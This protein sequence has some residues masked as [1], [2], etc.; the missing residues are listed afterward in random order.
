MREVIRRENVPGTVY[1]IHFKKKFHQ[2]RHYLGWTEGSD[3]KPRIDKH[4]AGAGSRLLRAVGAAGISFKV[5]RTWE[6]VDR[7]FE[8]KLKKQKNLRHQCP[9]CG[10]R[11]RKC[12]TS[13]LN[14]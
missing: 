6:N 3:I 12:R 10:P 2:T 7:H 9:H 13:N 5:V 8:R 11:K 1:L 4:K 14:Q